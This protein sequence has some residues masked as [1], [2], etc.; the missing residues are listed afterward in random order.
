MEDKIVFKKAKYYI[1]NIKLSA[2]EKRN[3]KNK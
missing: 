2:V 3:N 1:S